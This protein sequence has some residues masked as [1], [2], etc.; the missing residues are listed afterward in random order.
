[1]QQ[2]ALLIGSSFSKEWQLVLVMGALEL[3][4]SQ[5]GGQ[6]CCAA[7]L[8]CSA[9]AHLPAIAAGAQPG[10]DLVGVSHRHHLVPRLRFHC[11]DPWPDLQ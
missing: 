6:R 5:V 7:R 11:A 4:L 2:V 9:R 10:G 3:V 1:M 8:L